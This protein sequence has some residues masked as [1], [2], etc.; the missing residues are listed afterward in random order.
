MA[1]TVSAVKRVSQKVQ[2]LVGFFE[3]LAKI[4]GWPYLASWAHRITG[5]LLVLYIGFHIVTLSSLL[6]PVRFDA[7][8][9]L[10]GFALFVLLEFLLVVPVIYHALNG[11]RLILYEVFETR[12][13]ALVLK[14]VIALGAFYTFLLAVF[15]M[16]GNQSVSAP[17]FWVYTAAASAC[18]VFITVRKLRVSGASAF[19]KLQRISGA[20]LF[21]MVP[22][23][24]LFMHLNPAVGHD[25]QVIIAR[26]GNLFIKLVDLALVAGVI[27]HGS[28]GL[29]A[30]GQDYIASPRL[31]AVMLAVLVILALAFAW[32]GLT[33]IVRI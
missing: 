19:W 26:M 23:H 32:T 6:E 24:M 14:W 1:S 30:I 15:M 21:L 18:L 11:G 9:R 13:D 33:L 2:P 22:A 3:N 25:S 16:A 10:F 28:Y 8:M 17:F 4:R 29:Y 20:F 27:Y 31:R 12:R 5:V 7:K